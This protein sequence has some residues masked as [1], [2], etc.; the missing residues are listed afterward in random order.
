M[1]R[2][3]SDRAT[4]PLERYARQ[5]G[6]HI[7]DALEK[8]DDRYRITKRR[9]KRQGDSRLGNVPRRYNAPQADQRQSRK[10]LK[11]PNVQGC[12]CSASLHC[13]GRWVF[14]AMALG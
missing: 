1:T 4:Q 10:R 3:P 8:L 11:A 2:S 5:S 14:R 6:T 12:L 13:R 7:A 9:L